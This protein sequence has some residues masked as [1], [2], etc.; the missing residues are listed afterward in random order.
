MEAPRTVFGA[1]LFLVLL[2]ALQCDTFDMIILTLDGGP[3]NNDAVLHQNQSPRFFSQHF[4]SALVFLIYST[5]SN[6]PLGKY[7]NLFIVH[8]QYAFML[9]FRALSFTCL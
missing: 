6:Q 8:M 7:N 1:L 3:L 2:L 4:F 9:T 5:L